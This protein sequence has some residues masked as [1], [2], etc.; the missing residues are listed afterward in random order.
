MPVLSVS[1]AIVLRTRSFGES[2]KI[3][4][5]LSRDFGKVTGIAKGAKRS[6][7]RFVNTLEPFSL[8]NLRFQERAQSSLVFIHACDWLQVFKRLTTDL[9]RIAMASYMVEITDELTREREESRATFE[10]LKQGL[11]FLEE[12]GSSAS[13][14]T[15]FEMRLLALSGYQP[16]LEGCRRCGKKRPQ[17]VE[18]LM[19]RE[20]EEHGDYI[21]RWSFSP[22]DG[23]ILCRS[24]LPFRKEALPLSVEALNALARLQQ[25]EERPPSYSSLSGP[26]LKETRSI[27]P[28]FIQYQI[29]KELKSVSFL[30]TFCIT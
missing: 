17:P 25:L 12:Q 8:V 26:A 19:I 29:N 6:R 15:F 3:V 13:Y 27:L 5:L 2:D 7:R 11:V 24:C 10:H 20:A 9:E 28:R 22:R 23:G 21:P 16:M 18:S 30:E 1:P 14:L 4:S